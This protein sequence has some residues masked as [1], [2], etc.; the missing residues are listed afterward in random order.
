MYSVIIIGNSAVGKTSL[1]IKFADNVYKDSYKATIGIDFKSKKIKVNDLVIK[2]QVWDTAGQERYRTI[3]QNYYQRADGIILAYD[4]TDSES[5][6]EL[7]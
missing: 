4:S 7:G 5:F 3:S 6:E 1:M 2:L